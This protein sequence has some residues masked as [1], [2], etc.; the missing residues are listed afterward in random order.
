[1]RAT[2][3]VVEGDHVSTPE[4]LASLALTLMQANAW[5]A[6]EALSSIFV[7]ER[8]EILNSHTTSDKLPLFS[9]KKRRASRN[10]AAA[11][12]TSED[13]P[14]EAAFQEEL[15][16]QELWDL[17]HQF[18]PRE[19]KH[20]VYRVWDAETVQAAVR[21]RY[22]KA[23]GGLRLTTPPP[24][25]PKEET[26]GAFDRA[27]PVEGGVILLLKNGA[28]S[29]AYHDVKAFRNWQEEYASQWW[30]TLEEAH[31]QYELLLKEGASQ[32]K[33]SADED[34]E[35]WSAY[36]TAHIKGHVAAQ[37]APSATPLPGGE[38]GDENDDK[39]YWDLY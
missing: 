25:P 8:V 28:N 15:R 9:W 4:N 12:A 6:L 17:I 20:T 39:D 16:I 29:W 32:A 27:R 26:R 37:P 34:D 33:G 22:T 23:E 1:M 5:E 14:A 19:E 38:E 24:S 13:D 2:D 30:S 11:T 3:S 31:K 7:K 35:Y 21:F 10:D 36:E 18:E